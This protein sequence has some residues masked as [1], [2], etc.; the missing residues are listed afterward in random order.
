MN[1][2]IANAIIA[3]YIGTHKLSLDYDSKDAPVVF[4]LTDKNK[5]SQLFYYGFTF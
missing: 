4:V 3:D 2:D 5:Y 1:K